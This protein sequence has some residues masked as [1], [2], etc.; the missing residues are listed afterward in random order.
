MSNTNGKPLATNM[1]NSKPMWITHAQRL[2]E[3]ARRD[4]IRK[5][6]ERE[7]YTLEKRVK[8]AEGGTQ[9]ARKVWGA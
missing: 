1:T 9:S 8:I 6:R 3:K 2:V 5:A 4:L 7:L